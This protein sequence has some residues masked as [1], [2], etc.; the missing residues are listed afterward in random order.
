[1]GFVG[2]AF[3]PRQKTGFEGPERNKDASHAPTARKLTL[4]ATHTILVATS[5]FLAR[6]FPK[7]PVENKTERGGEERERE[8]KRKEGGR[9]EKARRGAR[10]QIT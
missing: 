6:V 5:T 1:M 7:L 2:F 4:D 8:K 9:E 10:K 3:W